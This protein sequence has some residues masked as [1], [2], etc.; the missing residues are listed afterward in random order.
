MET[1]NWLIE[2]NYSIS[3]RKEYT[4]AKRNKSIKGSLTWTLDS[5]EC[6]L[7]ITGTQE[8]E[9][10]VLMGRQESSALKT[11]QGLD[12]VSSIADNLKG[13]MLY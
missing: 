7:T 2:K 13:S 9:R 11:A 6:S 8:E 10:D 4:R 1:R 3:I 5:S 12:P